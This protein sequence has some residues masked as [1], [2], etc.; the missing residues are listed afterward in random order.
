VTRHAITIEVD[1]ERL[2][3]YTDRYLAFAWHLAQHNPAPHGDWEAAELVKRIGWEVI[4]RW[5]R[6]VEPEMYH[7]QAD[8]NYHQW[9]T[10][11]AR[12]EPPAGWS[13]R[14]PDPGVSNA[15]FHAGRWVPKAPEEVQAEIETRRAN[16]R[17]P[18]HGGEVVGS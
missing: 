3:S 16:G 18:E 4:R 15:E 17:Y 14:R 2:S 7:H 10:L 11:F 13:S 8:A 9:L 12:Y 5:L 1:G 6:G